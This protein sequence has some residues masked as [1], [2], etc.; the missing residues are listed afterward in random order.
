M[1]D[2]ISIRFRFVTKLQFSDDENLVWVTFLQKWRIEMFCRIL[3]EAW[4]L[5][6]VDRPT[7]AAWH[8]SVSRKF[9]F[10]RVN[11]GHLGK[12]LKTEVKDLIAK[13]KLTQ[14]V[15]VTGCKKSTATIFTRVQGLPG[16]L[17]C[18]T[19][20]RLPPLV[21]WSTTTLPATS[22]SSSQLIDKEE[23]L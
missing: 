4:K 1:R 7:T 22:S 13:D 19:I 3:K 8:V 2:A 21:V 16:A 9:I 5:N 20:L 15:V 6:R 11:I 14:N 12:S 17:F 10:C 23:E 18:T